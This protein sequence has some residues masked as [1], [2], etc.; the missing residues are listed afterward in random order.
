MPNTSGVETLAEARQH[1]PHATFVQLTA[2]ADT[3]A[4]IAADNDVGLDHLQDPWDPPADRL[5]PVA[6]DLLGTEAG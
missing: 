6:D 5:F 3:D 4:A 1:A 2:Y